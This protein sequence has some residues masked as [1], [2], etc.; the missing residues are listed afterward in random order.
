MVV[1]GAIDND[2]HPPSS[3]QLILLGAFRGRENAASL[4]CQYN[5]LHALAR[6]GLIQ[7]VDPNY[8]MGWFLLPKRVCFIFKRTPAG[9]KM[10]REWRKR[11]GA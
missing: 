9:L 3:N 8:G 7:A 10:V 11:V 4:G 5:E 2:R 6:R 1:R